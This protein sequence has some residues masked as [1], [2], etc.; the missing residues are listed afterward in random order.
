MVLKMEITAFPI[1]K[2]H[3]W[4]RRIITMNGFLTF[5]LM[6]IYLTIMGN[7]LI[8]LYVKLREKLFPLMEF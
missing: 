7:E 4:K 5:P 6:G 8:T 2:T 1:V 3:Q